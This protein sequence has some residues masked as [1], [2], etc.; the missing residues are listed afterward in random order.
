MISQDAM[1]MQESVTVK[2]ADHIEKRGTNA[3]GNNVSKIILCCSYNSYFKIMMINATESFET[4]GKCCLRGTHPK[5]E[6][7]ETAT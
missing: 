2:M 7:T 6:I 5:V 3:K 4:A 1:L